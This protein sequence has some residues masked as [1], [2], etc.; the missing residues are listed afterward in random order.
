MC[1]KV[2]YTKLLTVFDRE[3]LNFVKDYGDIVAQFPSQER[4]NWRKSL[5]KFMRAES[6]VLALKGK[7]VK[8]GA[9]ACKLK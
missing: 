2:K 1:E 3:C 4:E 9:V 5:V 8:S 6:S 7:M